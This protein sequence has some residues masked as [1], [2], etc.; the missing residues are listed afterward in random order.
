MSSRSEN[1]VTLLLFFRWSLRF[2]NFGCIF[3]REKRCPAQFLGWIFIAKR[4]GYSHFGDR[5]H[6]P[7]KILPAHGMN[8]GIGRRIEKINGVGDAIFNREF[9][10]VQ[11]VTQRPAQRLRVLYHSLQQLGYCWRRIFHIALMVWRLRIVVHDVHFFLSDDIA[12]EIFF[13]L[14]AMLQSH[15]QVASLVVVMEKLLRR[16]DFVDVLPSAARIWL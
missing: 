12:A 16:M 5:I 6:D 14:D 8:I 7:I 11:V 10:R 4:F 13:E 2:S 1:G 3:S 15:A 9:N